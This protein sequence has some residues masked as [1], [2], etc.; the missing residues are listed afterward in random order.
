MK[1]SP[2]CTKG[3]PPIFLELDFFVV[4]SG[5]VGVVLFLLLDIGDSCTLV[6]WAERKRCIARLP[7][8]ES[9]CAK[10]VAYC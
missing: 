5:L 7:S 9:R 6:V 8:E 1:R 3:V 10:V 2:P 4:V